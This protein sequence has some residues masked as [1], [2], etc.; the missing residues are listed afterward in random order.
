[1][2]IDITFPLSFTNTNYEVI[3]SLYMPWGVINTCGMVITTLNTNGCSIGVSNPYGAA[4]SGDDWNHY[5]HLLCI[6]K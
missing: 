6:G 3:G 4:G 2:Y 5:I 1:M